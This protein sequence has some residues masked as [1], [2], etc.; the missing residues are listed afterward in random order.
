[1]KTQNLALLISVIVIIAIA[2]IASTVLLSSATYK[3]ITLNDVQMEVKDSNITVTNQTE[4]QH[5]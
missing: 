3:N 1:M 4:Q 2:A 5:V